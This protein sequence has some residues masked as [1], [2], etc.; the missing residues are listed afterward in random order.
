LHI[1]LLQKLALLIV[2][3]TSNKLYYPTVSDTDGNTDYG[4]MRTII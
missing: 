2:R 1:F 4:V 3:M